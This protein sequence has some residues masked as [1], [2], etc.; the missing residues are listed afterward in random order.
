MGNATLPFD[1]AALDAPLAALDQLPR[2]LWLCGIVN[3][4]GRLA[5]R[6]DALLALRSELLAGRLP[7]HCDWPLGSVLPLLIHSVAEFDLPALCEH[8]EDIADQVLRSMLWHTD[9]IIDYRGS[10]SEDAAAQQAA[11]GFRD[12][13]EPMAHEIRDLLFVFGDIGDLVKF[14]RWD[15]TRGLLRSGAWQALL[16]IRELIEDLPELRE[17]VNKLGRARQTDVPDLASAP[18]VQVM[19]QVRTTVTDWR[20]IR[21]PDLPGET[22]GI[23]RS[24]RVSRMLPSEAV[25]LPHPRLRLIWFARHAERTLLTYEDMD[26]LREPV[27]VQRETWRPTTR[28]QP[29]RKLE[30]GPMILCVD[31]SGSMQGAAE[32]VAKA[33]VLEAMRVAHAQKRAC[34]VY[35]FSGPDEVI[36]REFAFDLPGI[37]SL[38]D[39]MTQSFNGGTDI[40]EPLERALNRL[41]DA[42]WQCADLLIASDG[43]FGAPPPIAARVRAA[44]ENLGLR[45]QGVLIGD[46]ETIGLIELADDIFWVGDWRRYG[47]GGDIPIH[48]KSLTAMYF[49]NALR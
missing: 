39:F 35:A 46:R 25:L 32:Q 14:N 20:D 10:M 23:E 27:A 13:W 38:L 37:D 11:Q 1:P 22:R 34:Y 18:E 19:E 36:E 42:A 28:P 31:T 44:R 26:T 29:E 2:G 49:P 4:L 48:D 41:E 3:S 24:G 5:P 9:R 17:M 12:E 47:A 21:L 16:R 30:M 6:L 15:L 40:S 8:H 43:E 33:L 45:V 7:A